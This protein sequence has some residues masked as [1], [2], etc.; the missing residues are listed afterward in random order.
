MAN[1]RIGYHGTGGELFVLYLKNIFLTIITLGIYSFWA[2][3]NVQKYLATK[4][5]WESERFTFHGTGKERFLAFLKAA[6]LIIGV[7]VI[8]F[9]ISYVLALVIGDTAA[10]IVSVIIIFTLF[11]A[12]IPFILVGKRRYLSSRTGYRN[13]RFG[14][15]GKSLDLAILFLKNV[16][17]V[18]ITLG[19]YYPFFSMKLETFNRNNTRYGNTNFQF[20]ADATEY[21]W[22]CVKGYLLSIVTLGIYGAWFMA[23][24]QNYTWGHTSFQGKK[25][26]SDITG[27]KIFVTILKVYAIVI[28]TLGIGMAWA[29]NMAMK[30]FLESVS[31]ESNVDFSSISAQ[32][33][34]GASATAEG[35]EAL[36]DAL[37]GFIG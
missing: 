1:Q 9:I 3:T 8:N 7:Y 15:D 27:G 33:D 37:E 17:L 19:I 16:P 14:F 28:F 11:I 5:E 30:V 6:A 29:I 12:I 20:E 26:S 35:L 24:L 10:G 32:P 2:K 22:I 18:I 13:L 21:F 31:L 4:V 23:T 25:F 36:A 34:T